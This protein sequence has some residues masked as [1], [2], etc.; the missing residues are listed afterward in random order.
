MSSGVDVL[1]VRPHHDQGLSLL[2]GICCEPLELEQL[3]AVAGAEGCRWAIYDPLVDRRSLRRVLRHT[4]PKLVAITGYH[5]MRLVMIDLARRIHNLSPAV[6]LVAGGVDVALDPEAYTQSDFDVLVH[7]GGAVTFQVLLAQW[8]RTGQVAK[9]PGTLHRPRDGGWIRQA[10]Q[11]VDS[12]TLPPPDRSHFLNHRSQFNYL[13]YGPVALL[14]SAY[15]CPYDCRFCC[16]KLLNDGHY[17][18]RPVLAVVAELEGLPAET[19]WIVDDT[20][21]ADMAR[22]NVLA[23]EIE[24]R[25][26]RKQLIIYA[27]AGEVVRAAASLSRLKQMGIVEIIVGLEAVDPERLAAYKKQCSADDNARCI[28]LL[29]DAGIRCI[30]LF[31][32]EPDATVA[33]FRQLREW[34]RENRLDVFSMSI[35]SPFPG[36]DD[37]SQYRHRICTDNPRHWD[38]RHLVMRPTHMGRLA[39]YWR[40]YAVSAGILRNRAFVWRVLSRRFNQR[41]RPHA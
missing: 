2:A 1:L 16:C 30:G 7:H 29:R 41:R 17:A 3:A 12:T 26:I 8:R 39:F 20:F 5:P 11:A 13:D 27:R 34:I 18:A 38:L 40:F 9:V 25:G 6:V 14:K 10:P 19:V 4:E 37:F 36:T 28:A 24:R 31:M 23:A 15:G 32:I 35:F 21:L 33:E 22:V